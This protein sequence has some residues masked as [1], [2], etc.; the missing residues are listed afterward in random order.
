[1][2][3]ENLPTDVKAKYLEKIKV[4]TALIR[5]FELKHGRDIMQK[6]IHCKNL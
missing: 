3:A 4:T 6:K 1:M 5:L 2:Y